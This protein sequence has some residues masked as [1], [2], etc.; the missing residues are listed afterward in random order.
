MTCGGAEERL[1]LRLGLE[2]VLGLGLRIRQNGTG[3]NFFFHSFPMFSMYFL[4]SFVYLS[5]VCS[6]SLL[7]SYVIVLARLSQVFITY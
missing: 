3:W 2:L 7:F 4:C 1:T 5:N 6:F